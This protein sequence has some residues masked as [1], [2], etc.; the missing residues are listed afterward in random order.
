MSSWRV[1]VFVL[2]LILWKHLSHLVFWLID[3]H[4]KYKYL[5]DWNL[6]K[7]TD[8][9]VNVSIHVPDSNLTRGNTIMDIANANINL[10]IP[11]PETL[12]VKKGTQSILHFSRSQYV[13]NTLNASFCYELHIFYTRYKIDDCTELTK[14][15]AGNNLSSIVP[16]TALV[17]CSQ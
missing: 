14:S 10:N 9:I 8:D 4:C 17:C 5:W 16:R 6:D 2:C 15:L 1:W 3:P 7:T 13:R 11:H 12:W